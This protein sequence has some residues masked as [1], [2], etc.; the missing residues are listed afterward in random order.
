MRYKLLVSVNGKSRRFN[1]W[2]FNRQTQAERVKREVLERI[3]GGAARLE[4]FPH[5][6]PTPLSD[7]PDPDAVV[8]W[9]QMTS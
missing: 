1:I 4:V 5:S 9:I 2:F 7:K 3:R 6:Y 8:D